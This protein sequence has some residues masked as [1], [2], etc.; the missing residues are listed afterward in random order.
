[1]LAS[2][3]FQTHWNSG[4]VDLRTHGSK[5]FRHPTVG[6][7]TLSFDTFEL[8]CGQVDDVR[9]IGQRLL[10]LYPTTEEARNAL[11]LITIWEQPQTEQ[12]PRGAI[13]ETNS[14]Q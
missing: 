1:M 5:S 13:D 12:T 4:D 10:T 6:E 14:S 7:V 2:T 9:Q 11:R 8:P 3:N